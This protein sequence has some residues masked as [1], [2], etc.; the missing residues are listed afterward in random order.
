MKWQALPGWARREMVGTAWLGLAG[1]QGFGATR[2]GFDWLGMAGKERSGAAWSGTDGSVKE[3][4]VRLGLER[5][6][7]YGRG[8]A[9]NGRRVV[10]MPDWART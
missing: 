6:G 7:P 8:L 10:A 4:Q 1:K 9:R 5:R 2:P 3:L